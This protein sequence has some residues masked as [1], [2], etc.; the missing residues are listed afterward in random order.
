MD[1]ME[2]FSNSIKFDVVIAHNIFP[3]VDPRIIDFINNYMSITKKIILTI[4][5]YNDR[6]VTGGIIFKKISNFIVIFNFLQRFVI[7]RFR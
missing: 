6:N 7:K 1:F 5:T 4:W 3:H 2:Y